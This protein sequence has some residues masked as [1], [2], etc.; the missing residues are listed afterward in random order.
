MAAFATVEDYAARF[1]EPADPAV[2][3][4]CLEDATRLIASELAAAGSDPA[5]VDPGVLMQVCREVAHRAVG[6]GAVPFGVSQLT[7]TAGP[8]SGSYSFANPTGDA[9]LTK[10]ER[11]MLGLVGAARAASVSVGWPRC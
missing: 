11:R 5:E 4:E 3:A 9:Y 10:A 1:G 8:Y 7:Q 2:L 6:G